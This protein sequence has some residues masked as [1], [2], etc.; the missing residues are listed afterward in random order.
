MCI[1]DRVEKEKSEVWDVLDEVIREHPVLLNRAPTLHRLGIQAFEPM[2][3]EGKAIQLHPLVCAAF[4][5]DFDGDQMAV[6]VP[7]S[8]EAQMEARTLML[9]TNN[10]LFP[11]NGE[12]SIVPSQDVVLGLYY[13]TRERTNG[14]G[15][16]MIFSDI[17][18]VQRALDNK[19]VEVTAK[20]AVRLTEWV[21]DK[22]NG[23]EFVA[24]TKMV[25]TTVG[26][27]LLSE[28]LP[29]GLAFANI[30]KALKKKEISRLINASFRKCGLKETVVFADKLLQAGFRLATVSYTHLTLPTSDLV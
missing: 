17:I 16:G 7:L 23:D 30:N 4:N 14:L 19:V 24:E 27:A 6:H 15:E 1:R 5:A 3:I 2:L 26:R 21:K 13:A 28:I 11:A 22:A 18:E 12:P 10:V 29:K 8:I 20:I 25:D 9:A